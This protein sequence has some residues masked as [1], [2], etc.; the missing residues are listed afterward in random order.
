MPVS[1]LDA[2]PVDPAEG[3]QRGDEQELEDDPHEGVNNDL[4][5]T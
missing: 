1:H 2:E 4:Q 3:E 5:D